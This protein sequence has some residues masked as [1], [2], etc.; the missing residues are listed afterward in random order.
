MRWLM[1]IK[2]LHT[3]WSDGWGGQEIRIINEMIAVR[4]KGIEV[5]LACRDN[6]TIKNKAIENNI[7]V[8]TLP[9]RGNVDF[10]TMFA[11]IK[12]V[13]EYKIDIINTHSGKDTWVGGLAAKFSGAKFIRTRHLS[14]KIRSSRLNFINEL[15][16]YV[17]TTGE[18]VKADMIKYNRINPNKIV[19][20]AS[21]IDEKIF[22]PNLYDIAESKK[23]FKMDDSI[24][25][26]NVAVLRDCKRHDNFLEI[27]RRLIDS[28]KDKKFKFYIAGEGPMRDFVENKI[29]ELSLENDV[30]LLGHIS[31]VP[32]FLKTL[33]IFLFTSDEREGVP[34]SVM[35]ALLMNK[36]VVSTN[37]GSTSDLYKENN[38]LISDVDLE[39]VYKNV[40][41][42]VENLDNKNFLN[43]DRNFIVENFSKDSSTKK[44]INCY[45]EMLT[46]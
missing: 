34:Q 18:S 31:N 19:S 9:F 4:E 39:S 21:G 35:Q 33:D 25:I 7:K 16:D 40:C 11:L 24:I 37:D 23:L 27:A 32:Q 17:F 12:I 2:V 43:L 13:K 22:D 26:G 15:A 20:I 44:I 3:E 42:M 1:G 46:V 29:K 8:F 28:Y 41:K 6:S 10:K 45:N 38:F 30:I 14:N 36:N 5:F